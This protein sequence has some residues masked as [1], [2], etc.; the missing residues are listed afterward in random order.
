M[1]GRVLARP[2]IV[3]ALGQACARVCQGNR[4]EASLRR[5]T[6]EPLG[7]G[8]WRIRGEAALRNRHVQAVPPGLGRIAPDGVTLFDHTVVVRGRGTLDRR[9]C[10]LVVEAV[11][12]DSDPLGLARLLAGAAGREHRI[13]RCGELLP[14]E[15]PR[16]AGPP[17]RP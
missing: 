16:P 14:A 13:A 6:A 9:R 12:L 2:D 7:E 11:E 17:L 8:R 3:A 5:V 10:V 4:S 1:T 15:P